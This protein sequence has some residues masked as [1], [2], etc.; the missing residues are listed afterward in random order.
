LLQSRFLLFWPRK[1]R[2]SLKWPPYT[3]LL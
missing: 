3:G 2:A 1:W